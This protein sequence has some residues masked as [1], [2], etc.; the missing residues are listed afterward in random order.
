M[1]QLILIINLIIHSSIENGLDPHLAIAVAHT[2]SAFN[3][4]AK[5]SAGEIGIGQLK[6]STGKFI[7]RQLSVFNTKENIILMVE[8]LKL[9]EQ[10]YG[11]LTDA[12]ISCYNRGHNSKKINYGYVKKV[13]QFYNK[14]NKSIFTGK[15]K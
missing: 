2:E 5:G 10:K 13:K 1:E 12:S 15:I 11:K 14:L 9:C 7:N 3:P 6:P 8:Y 4:R